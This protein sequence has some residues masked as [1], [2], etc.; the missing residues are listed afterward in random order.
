MG[1]ARE[2]KYLPG[3]GFALLGGVLIGRAVGDDEP[4]KGTQRVRLR[5]VN[6]RG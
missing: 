1:L 4:G 5:N 2:I 6:S 3:E